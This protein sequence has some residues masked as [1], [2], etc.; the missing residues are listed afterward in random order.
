MRLSF[1]KFR[2]L[3]ILV[4]SICIGIV[5]TSLFSKWFIRPVSRLL[6]TSNSKILDEF[7]FQQSSFH[8][9]HEQIRD[10]VTLLLETF[11]RKQKLQE[12]SLRFEFNEYRNRF[13]NFSSELNQKLQQQQNLL[14][15]ITTL[16]K[17]YQRPKIFDRSLDDFQRAFNESLFYNLFSST[18]SPML[19]TTTTTKGMK[20]RFS[21]LEAFSKQLDKMNEQVLS[22]YRQLQKLSKDSRLK[23]EQL[24]K[25]TLRELLQYQETVI[26]QSKLLEQSTSELL[27]KALTKAEIRRIREV[28]E[29]K[30]EKLEQESST[31]IEMRKT[32]L[33]QQI[34]RFQ[35]KLNLTDSIYEDFMGK[36]KAS[37]HYTIMNDITLKKVLTMIDDRDSGIIFSVYSPL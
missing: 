26:T 9:Y 2:L 27:P 16:S 37:I 5:K 14:K 36:K 12:Q 1:N 25:H 31:W 30:I 8:Q 35:E 28:I 20:K 24:L 4:L 3:S 7:K 23:T 15:D 34:K 18:Y 33:E 10:K 21:D 32:I 17:R 11:R 22:S 19:Q 13:Q 6:E 29:K